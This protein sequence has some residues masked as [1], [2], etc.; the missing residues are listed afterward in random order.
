MSRSW[1]LRRSLRLGVGV[2]LA[3]ALRNYIYAA[4]VLLQCPITESWRSKSLRISQERDG[5]DVTFQSYPSE[6]PLTVNISL[7]VPP[8]IHHVL[9]GMTTTPRNW[10][11]ARAACLAM[12]PGYNS[13]L[14]TD[15]E[16]GDFVAR[17]F[18]G[19]VKTWQSYPYTIQ[20]A[21]SLRYMIMYKY[22]GIFLD[23]DLHCLRSLDPL[24]QFSFV[25]PAARPMGISNGFFMASPHHPFLKALVENLPRFNI[26]WFG[27]PYATVM[28]STGCHYMSA[29]HS[30]FPPT[31]NLR[32][33]WGPNNLH[34]LS[35]HVKT[36]LFEHLGSSSW[37]SLDI[38]IFLKFGKRALWFSL[39]AVVVI[40]WG[41]AWYIVRRWKQ[42][43]RLTL[44]IRSKTKIDMGPLS[45][46]P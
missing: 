23:L 15:A 25:A 32:V 34:R 13:K 35:G 26:H 1:L 42:K 30:M 19:M 3:V 11:S 18:P 20:K 40:T 46:G 22:G 7:P 43:L 37:H 8:I 2:I 38:V 14:W 33:L 17:E 4:F 29:I 12:H 36:P 21:D 10:E 24:R 6:P 44:P 41:V 9:L 27:I 39:C 45:C 5:F 28:F 31:E 16:A